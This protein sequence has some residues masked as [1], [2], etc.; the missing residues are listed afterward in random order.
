MQAYRAESLDLAIRFLAAT[1]MSFQ[2]LSCSPSAGSLRLGFE[3]GLPDLR[4]WR[5]KGFPYLIFYRDDAEMVL[6]SRILHGSRHIPTLIRDEA[7]L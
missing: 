6:V 7:D 5:I 4:S 1:R 2:F 3:V